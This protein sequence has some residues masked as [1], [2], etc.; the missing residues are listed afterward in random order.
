MVTRASA[1]ASRTLHLEAG[2]TEGT[3]ASEPLIAGIEDLS[4]TQATECKSLEHMNLH[5]HRESRLHHSNWPLA[6]DF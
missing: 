5:V 4:R 1:G 2:T 6:V 3:A